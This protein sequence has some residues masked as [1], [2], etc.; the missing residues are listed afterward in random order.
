MLIVTV[1]D[2]PP[3]L[4][5]E[6]KS[7][8]YPA[9]FASTEF[10]ARLPVP[11]LAVEQKR[12]SCGLQATDS[13]EL[14]AGGVRAVHV[15]PSGDVIMPSPVPVAATAQNSP[16]SGAHVRPRHGL[17][18]AAARAVQFMPSGDVITRLVPSRAQ[19]QNRPR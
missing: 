10:I 19:A 16:I 2:V 4:S 1:T 3:P 8:T 14:S 7:P 11:L 5:S 6:I 13:H 9:S 12:P 15:M 18:A 17:A